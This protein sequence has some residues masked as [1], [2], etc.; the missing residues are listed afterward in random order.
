MKIKTLKL[1]DTSD[2]ADWAQK[3]YGMNNSEWHD[4]I[5]RPLMVQYFED[6]P[7][8]TFSKSKEPENIFEEHIND[9]LDEFPEFEGK[10]S[11]IFTN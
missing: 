4:K 3:K 5:W 8:T 2:F 1:V 7:Y 11:L 6:G 9:F 10:V